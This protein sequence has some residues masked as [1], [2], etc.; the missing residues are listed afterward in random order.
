MP[1]YGQCLPTTPSGLALST[2]SFTATDTISNTALTA[3]LRL[4]QTVTV[5]VNPLIG[6]GKQIALSRM[7]Y[8]PIMPGWFH[9]NLWYRTAFA[10]V[11]PAAAPPIST[12]CT[13]AFT[14]LTAGGRQGVE[15]LVIQAGPVLPGVNLG[16]RPSMA[17]ADYLEGQNLLTKGGAAPGMTNC[18]FDGASARPTTLTNDQLIV[19]SP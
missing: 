12:P 1:V 2:V 11:A 4:P 8:H 7:R 16:S 18:A 9:E 3:Y 5:N 13:G 15:A 6:T 17:I 14:T 19:V 10:A